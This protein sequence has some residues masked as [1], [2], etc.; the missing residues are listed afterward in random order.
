MTLSFLRTELSEFGVSV[1]ILEPGFFATNLTN[2]KAHE[3]MLDK[4][5]KSLSSE[6]REEYG[7]HMLQYC[8]FKLLQLY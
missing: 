8:N 5:W 4:Q 7:E 6:V 3:A 1:C 2:T